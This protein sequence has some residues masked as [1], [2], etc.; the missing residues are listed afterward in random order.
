MNTTVPVTL[1]QIAKKVGLS[2]SAVSYAL[3]D[4]PRIAPATRR[5]VADVARALGYR[6]HP[7]VVALMTHVRRAQ[8]PGNRLYFAFIW[9]EATRRQSEIDPLCRLVYR[10]ARARAELLGIDLIPFWLR[11]RGMTPRR[12]QQILVARGIIGVVFSPCVSATAV[13]QEW[14][15]DAFS[16]AVI[17]NAPWRV[18]LHRA[19]HHH[20]AGMTEMVQRVA[21]YPGTCVAL[22]D[23]AVNER[24]GRAWEAAFLA[25][26][27]PQR[28]ARARLWVGSPAET[29]R[30]R[31][32]LRRWQPAVVIASNP[33]FQV[34]LGNSR[35]FM[36]NCEIAGSNA[37]GIDQ[38]WSAI[39]AHAVD[40]VFGQINRNERG[41]PREPKIVHFNGRWRP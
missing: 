6:P 35:W 34:N 27:R 17:G 19:G 25:F 5:R 8:S 32:F 2:I 14:D 16:M 22:L 11:D 20:F 29:A 38:D 33:D 13:D 1:A 36:L 40:L 7:A 41:V 3:R 31:E 9:V 21:E 26:S 15:W 28:S 10:G 30:R 39:A 37:S 24:S 18:A 4:H 12:L 23:R